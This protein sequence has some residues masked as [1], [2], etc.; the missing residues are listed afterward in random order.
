MGRIGQKAWNKGTKGVCKPNKTSFQKG[1]RVSIATEFKKGSMIRWKGDD[2]SYQAKHMWVYKHLGRPH[3]CEECGN[4]KLSHRQYHWANISGKYK[5]T[6]D[7]WRRL[8]A[9]CHKLFDE[10]KKHA[11]EN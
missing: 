2:A 4:K 1:Q 9:K 5:R 3:F 10:D 8:C 7:D 11:K 6:M